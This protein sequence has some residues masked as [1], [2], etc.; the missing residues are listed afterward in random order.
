MKKF[1]F[2]LIALLFLFILPLQ[3]MAGE[4]AAKGDTIS[5]EGTIQGYNCISTG[6]TC[7]IGKEDPLIETERV[8]VLFTKDSTFYLIPNM[9]RAILARHIN[10]IV[11]ITG[12]VNQKFKSLRAEKFEVLTDGV[13]KKTWPMK[14]WV[15][16]I[17]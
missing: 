13:W 15:W 10:Q 16:T 11:R 17:N 7:P 2:I 9:D 12:P 14:G 8:F 5:V 4:K 1:I 6:R 3:G